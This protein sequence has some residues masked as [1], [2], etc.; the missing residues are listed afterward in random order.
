MKRFLLLTTALL[1]GCVTSSIDEMVYQRH[2]TASKGDATVVILGRRH[3]PDYETEPD[4]IQCIG[5]HIGN[6][7]RSVGVIPELQFVNALY[8][9]FEPR[10]APMQPQDI[11]RLMSYPPV[12]SRMEELKVDY[13][14]W[15][16]GN[17]TRTEGSGS[18]TCA[19]GPGGGGCFGFGSWTND[20]N[21]EA[22]IW[23]LTESSEVGRISTSASGTSYMPAV[24]VP[25]PIIAP[26]RGTACDGL[27]DQLVQFLASQ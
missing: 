18:M 12:R 2:D 8:P 4:F 24:F 26:V 10:T 3:A 27:G 15:V 5:K 22:V 11:Q 21:Y 14:V 25:I 16:D 17:T 9:W 6:R 23:D 13:L 20:S 7:A 19:V 1:S